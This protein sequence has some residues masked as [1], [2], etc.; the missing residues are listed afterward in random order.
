M[1]T[2]ILEMI[3]FRQYFRAFTY[4]YITFI[5]C[6]L[7]TVLFVLIFPHDA[8]SNALVPSVY[9]E[10]DGVYL[11]RNRIEYG[12]GWGSQHDKPYELHR[13]AQNTSNLI[14]F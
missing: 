10:S 9:L 4:S 1:T 3:T 11:L 5:K 6:A 12:H 13:E 14:N 7:Q 8:R 2:V